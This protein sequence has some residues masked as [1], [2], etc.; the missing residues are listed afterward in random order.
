VTPKVKGQ[1][2]TNRYLT[3]QRTKSDAELNQGMR[4]M[5][6]GMQF[7]PR[8]PGPQT[9]VRRST[10][11][12]YAPKGSRPMGSRMSAPQYQKQPFRRLQYNQMSCCPSSRIRPN[13]SWIRGIPV[14]PK[15]PKHIR[16]T[17]FPSMVRTPGTLS[18]TGPRY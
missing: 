11:R 10:N 6:I 5:T 13:N 1:I 9:I 15:P 7:R 16:Q 4:Q 12:F 14:P 18:H 3:T 17:P 2:W 8:I